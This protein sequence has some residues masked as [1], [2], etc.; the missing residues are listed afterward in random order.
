MLQRQVDR[1]ETIH[2]ENLNSL[3][4]K[5]SQLDHDLTPFSVGKLPSNQGRPIRLLVV[6][7]SDNERQLMAYLLASSGFDVQVARDGE[8]ALK[9][10]TGAA[11]TAG[12]GSDGHA[13]AKGEWPGNDRADP[14]RYAIG[15][16]TGLC[17]DRN[18]RIEVSA[19]IQPSWNGWFLKPVNVDHLIETIRR[20]NE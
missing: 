17:C 4:A 19:Q 14:P 8:E 20:G 5:F 16:T 12:L 18:A 7:D 10:P 15:S 13:D 11:R 3:L 9:V 1:G 6:E 2:A